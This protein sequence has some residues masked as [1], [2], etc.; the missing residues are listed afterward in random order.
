MRAGS[1]IRCPHRGSTVTKRSPIAVFLL[2]FPTLGIY[3]WYWIIKTKTE[4]NQR[5]AQIPTAWIWLIPIV[6]GLYWLWKYSQGV[7]SVTRK[8][9]AAIAMVLLLFTGPIADA[10]FQSAYNETA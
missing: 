4:M 2:A 6:G 9:G 10:V 8:Y 7:E 1:T 3:S 5:G